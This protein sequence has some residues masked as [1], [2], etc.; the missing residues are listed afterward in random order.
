M[1]AEIIERLDKVKQHGNRYRSICPVHDGNNPSAL[2]LTEDNNHI[3]I[4]CHVCGATGSDVVRE[5]GLSET[6]LFNEVSHNPRVNSYFSEDQKDQ[7]LEDAFYIEI[8]EQQLKEG[9]VPSS[10]EYRRH[11]LSQQ[12]VKI[13]DQINNKEVA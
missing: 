1:L 2:S 13:L 8:Y 5:L 11:R 7:A 9:H 3:L 12:R 10:E 4:H 6:V